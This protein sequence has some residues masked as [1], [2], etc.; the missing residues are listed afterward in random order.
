MLIKLPVSELKSILP[1]LSRVVPKATTT[2]AL[3]GVRIHR[4]E[5][6]HITLTVTDQSTF[7]SYR[8]EQF[9]PG[10]RWD[11]LVPFEILQR[12]VKSCQPQDDI[13]IIHGSAGLKIA[14]PLGGRRMERSL[15]MYDLTQC[16]SIP[17]V[18]GPLEPVSEEFKAA[19]A[20][21]LDCCSRDSGRLALEGAWVDVTDPKAHY[22]MG[23]DGRHLHASNSF[24]LGLKDSLLV[25]NKRFLNWRGFLDDGPWRIGVQEPWI[26]LQSDHWTFLVTKPEVEMPNWKYVV[27]GEEQAT[28]TLKFDETA[29]EALLDVI[30]RLPGKDTPNTPVTVDANRSGVSV[31]GYDKGDDSPTTIPIA[32]V[33]IGGDPIRFALNREF[34]MKA[35]K[36]GL[37]TLRLI[38]DKSP[39]VFS[40]PGRRLVVMPVRIETPGTSSTP[41][42]P[43][44][45]S[46]E[47][48]PEPEPETMKNRINP[49]FETP[50]ITQTTRSATPPMEPVPE[51]QPPMLA[52]QRQ[53]ETLKDSL[54]ALHGEVG[55]IVRLLAQANREKRTTDRE[56]EAVREKL[57]EIQ[58]V[59]I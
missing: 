55:D 36:W 51:S 54:K 6:G 38:D 59:R 13:E 57:R 18:E 40:A 1:G 10:E 2:P 11:G 58:S 21:A 22:V 9:V 28:T 45:P 43:P 25:P 29:V 56:V 32:G 50:Q 15:P 8:L 49:S 5:A 48:E 46:T 47:P 24:S 33:E 31:S 3:Q 34:L 39:M 35:L 20:H 52:A 42:P 37:H 7:A 17:V 53:L 14:H 4:D 30:P 12:T 23:T 44:P 26:H 41:P 19:I 27:P 16:P